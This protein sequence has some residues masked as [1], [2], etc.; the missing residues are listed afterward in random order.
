MELCTAFADTSGVVTTSYWPG[1]TAFLNPLLDIPAGS[2]VK[3]NQ[4]SRAHRSAQPSVR[5]PQYPYL[6]VCAED[7]IIPEHMVVHGKTIANFTLNN[8]CNEKKQFDLTPL[9]RS[10]P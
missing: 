9:L 5:P 2:P 10:D 4:P 8:V 7:S 6:S 3:Y 1:P